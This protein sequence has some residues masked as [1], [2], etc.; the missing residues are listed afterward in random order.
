MS[1]PKMQFHSLCTLSLLCCEGSN[2]VD[3]GQVVIYPAL[4]VLMIGIPEGILHVW[5]NPSMPVALVKKK[6]KKV[7]CILSLSR[8]PS[9]SPYFH[10]LLFFFLQVCWMKKRLKSYLRQHQGLMHHTFST[11]RHGYSNFIIMPNLFLRAQCFSVKFKSKLWRISSGVRHIKPFC[12]FCT[13]K[14]GIVTLVFL[15]LWKM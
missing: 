6:K 5:G 8:S 15:H 10:P 13:L 14:L 1:A 4:C 3:R 7:I 2:V 12:P 11:G 9:L